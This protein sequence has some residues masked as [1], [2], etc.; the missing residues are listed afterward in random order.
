[1]KYLKLLES[2]GEAAFT[3]C[4]LDGGCIFW[5]NRHEELLEDNAE[6]DEARLHPPLILLPVLLAI[7]LLAVQ[8]DH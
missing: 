6:V 7:D 4:L 8:Q 5:Q 1:V 3:A 2:G